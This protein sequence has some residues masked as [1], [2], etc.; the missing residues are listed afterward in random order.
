MNFQLIWLNITQIVQIFYFCESGTKFS[1]FA[2]SIENDK[3][4]SQRLLSFQEILKNLNKKSARF[5]LRY[6]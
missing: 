4:F 1:S 2:F 6:M 3:N 5:A